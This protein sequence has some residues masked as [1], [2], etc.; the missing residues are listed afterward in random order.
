MDEVGGIL[1][2][3]K[4]YDVLRGP[5]GPLVYPAGFVWI[6][7]FIR[8]CFG[9]AVRPVQYLFAVIHMVLLSFA[10]IAFRKSNVLP[11]YFLPLLLASRRVLSIF[12]LR[13]FNDCVAMMFVY[14]AIASAAYRKWMFATIALSL[15]LSVK[16]NVL[17]FVPFALLLLL[18]TKGFLTVLRYGLVAAAIQ[19]LV[20]VPFLRVA[21]KVYDKK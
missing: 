14:A 16:M 12:V 13:L 1:G 17:L 2:G 7:A 4:Q 10:V 6:F 15:G 3:E 19:V 5:T 21:P 11:W 9:T 18:R 20:A 8:I